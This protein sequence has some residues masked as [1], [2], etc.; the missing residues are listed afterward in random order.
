MKLK[1]L[2]YLSLAAFLAMPVHAFAIENVHVEEGI[3]GSQQKI[4]CVLKDE[5]N[6]GKGDSFSF[7]IVEDG[8]RSTIEV[9]ESQDTRIV[10]VTSD[11]DS[12][13][14][15]FNK[16]RGELYSSKTGETIHLPLTSKEETRSGPGMYSPLGVEKAQADTAYYYEY[17][18]FAQ[19]RKVVVESTTAA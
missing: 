18:S 11:K 17:V 2:S 3:V 16:V 13:E 7:E 6:W 15:V 8:V 10:K 9:L 5:R 14:L 1:Q 4:Q 19:I 12:Y